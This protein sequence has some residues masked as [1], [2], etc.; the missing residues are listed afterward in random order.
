MPRRASSATGRPPPSCPRPS[1][2]PGSVAWASTNSVAAAHWQ[3]SVRWL[4]PPRVQRCQRSSSLSRAD[5]YTTRQVAYD[6][7]KPCGQEL[8]VKPGRVRGYHVSPKAART[9]TALIAF[10]EQ[11]IRPILAGARVRRRG[12]PPRLRG[13][14][15]RRHKFFNDLA[16][17]IDNTVSTNSPKPSI[18][19][20]AADI[21]G[22]VGSACGTETP[23]AGPEP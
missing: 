14:P 22:D 13:P 17:C 2:A 7:R 23:E 5:N 19:T 1:D 4:L 20:R 15:H 8:V 12:R 6:L 9:L 16:H 18:G 3:E 11:V 21:P 10:R